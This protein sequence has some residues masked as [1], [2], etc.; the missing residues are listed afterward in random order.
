M[1]TTLTVSAALC[2][3]RQSWCQSI[4][5]GR[6]YA[7]D[8]YSHLLDFTVDAVRMGENGSEL[9]LPV[10]GKTVTVKVTACA[11]LGEVRF[12]K[13]PNPSHGVQCPQQEPAHRPLLWKYL[14]SPWLCT[15]EADEIIANTPYEE[16]PYWHIERA[17]VK[18]TR[19]VP[20]EII[21]NG[22]WP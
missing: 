4:S 12:P 6:N 5:E 10:G 15:Q 19:K 3:T 17:R 7:S 1:P 14:I 22:A 11:M 13:M 2:S 8:G 20:L 16:K 18:G 21:V 9:Q